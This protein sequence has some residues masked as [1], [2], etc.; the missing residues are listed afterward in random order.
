[1][2]S[3]IIRESCRTSPSLDQLSDG[4]ERLWWRLITIADDH[5]RFD[6]DP[7]V[8]EGNAFPLKIGRLKLSTIEKWLAELTTDSPDGN[9]PLVILYEV[10]GRRYGFIPS[11]F[12]HQRRR[13]S[14]PKFPAPEEGTLVNPKQV[15]AFRRNPPPLP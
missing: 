3:R 4:A 10:S 12:K 14:K 2:P 9:L 8:V 5:G 1:M 6:A 13:E 11:W 15:A 7:R